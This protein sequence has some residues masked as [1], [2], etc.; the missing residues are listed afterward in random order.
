MRYAYRTQRGYYPEDMSK[1]NQ[2]AFKVIKNLNGN[3]NVAYFG[4]FDGHGKV[5]DKGSYYVRDSIEQ[6][7]KM[8]I[9]ASP[10][11]DPKFDEKFS[12]CSSK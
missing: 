12:K 7:L 8:Y 4:V 9:G 10:I 1:N 5:G 3:N 11:T 6:K 2:D